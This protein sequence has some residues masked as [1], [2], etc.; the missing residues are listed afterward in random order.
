MRRT[1]I[2]L[3]ILTGFVSADALACVCNPGEMDQPLEKAEVAFVGRP[4]KIEALPP[5]QPPATVWQRI[6]GSFSQALGNSPGAPAVAAPEFLGSVRVTFEVSE[7]L[8]GDGPKKFQI[9]TGYGDADCG[10]AVSISKRYSIYARRI[11]GAL[12]TSYCFGSAEYVRQQRQAP[13]PHDS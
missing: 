1:L 11:N 5:K 8:K 7:Y 10:L 13:C 12:R 3:T 2:A 9:M 4:V 6:K